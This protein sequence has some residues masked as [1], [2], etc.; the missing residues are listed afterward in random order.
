MSRLDDM[1]GR[2]GECVTVAAA[3]R[4]MGRSRTTI[5]QMLKDGRLKNVCQGTMVDVRSICEYIESP[6]TANTKARREKMIAKG[7]SRFH[8]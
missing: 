6:E 2:Y 8:V 5:N 7:R 3:E 1:L 4:I